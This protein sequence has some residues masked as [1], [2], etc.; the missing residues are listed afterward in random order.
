MTNKNSLLNTDFERT[1]P[2]REVNVTD[3][4]RIAKIIGE[5]L[6]LSHDHCIQMNMVEYKEFDKRDHSFLDITHPL[7]ERPSIK[8]ISAVIRLME[9]RGT[10]PARLAFLLGIPNRKT[11][12][13]A[14]WMNGSREIPYSSWRRITDLAGITLTTMIK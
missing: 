11:E 5:Q 2:L 10:S 14:D 4:A 9:S 7:Y 13:F 1:P 6:E 12:T 8:L 3:Q